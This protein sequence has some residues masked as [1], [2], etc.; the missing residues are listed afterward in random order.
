MENWGMIVYKQTLITNP[1]IA[2]FF[3]R[4][5]S[6]ITICHEISHE[7]FGDLGDIFLI[8]RFKLIFLNKPHVFISVTA[9][10]W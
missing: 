8:F 9:D 3:S 2:P 6:S 5:T 1:A 7:W 4:E 10:H